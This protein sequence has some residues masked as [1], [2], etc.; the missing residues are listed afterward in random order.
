MKLTFE[1]HT[2]YTAIRQ[3]QLG[4][5]EEN[6][7]LAVFCRRNSNAR[8]KAPKINP[9]ALQLISSGARQRLHCRR[10]PPSTTSTQSNSR[11]GQSE[12]NPNRLRLISSGMR[13]HRNSLPRMP[14]H[15]HHSIE[16]QNESE[17]KESTLCPKGPTI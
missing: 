11:M 1:M 9:Y 7:F 5:C 4:F 6:V 3:A 2:A 14:L 12:K 17:R 16:F 8:F 15:H 13:R 10:A